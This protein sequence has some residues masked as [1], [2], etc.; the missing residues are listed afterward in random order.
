MILHIS[1]LLYKCKQEYF[2]DKDPSQLIGTVQPFMTD[3]PKTRFSGPCAPR[4]E[5]VNLQGTLKIYSSY[6]LRDYLLHMYIH[7]NMYLSFHKRL[8]IIRHAIYRICFVYE[9]HNVC[10]EGKKKSFSIFFLSIFPLLNL[11]YNRRK[12]IKEEKSNRGEIFV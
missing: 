10:T 4:P 5:T 3:P 6:I 7:H 9:I 2:V 1:C 11:M 12:G 8:C